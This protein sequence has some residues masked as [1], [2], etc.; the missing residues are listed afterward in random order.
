MKKSRL[1]GAICAAVIS[2]I[3]LPS[4]AA[5][6]VPAGLNPGDS[7]QLIFLTAGTRTA[8]DS[9]IGSYN[10]FVQAQ[11]ELNPTLT[12]TDVGVTYTAV[13]SAYNN[14]GASGYP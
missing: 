6:I 11:A 5:T 9:T 7:Y 4:Y 14:Q 8:G 3:T 10:D 1:I 12:G 2:F 13:A